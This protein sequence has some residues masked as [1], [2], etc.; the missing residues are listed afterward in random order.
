MKRA[1]SVSLG[2]PSRDKTVLVKLNGVEIMVERIGTGGDV[3]KTRRLFSQLDG[4]VDVFSLG[5]ID[6]YVHL[7]GRDYPIHAAHK[8][9]Q[10]VRQTPIVDGRM[11]KYALEGHLFERTAPLIDEPFHF[12]HAFIPFGTDRI[13]LIQS[14]SQVSDVVWIGDLMFIFGLPIAVKGLEQ[15]K[16]VARLLLP[17]AGYLPISMLF[18]P[19]ALDESPQPKYERYWARADLIA[20]D[21]HYI[22][23]YSPNDLSG[24]TI[25]TNTTTP[26]N[27]N[28]LKQSKV[29]RVIT[30][31]P[32]YDGRSFG[33]NMMEAVLTAYSGHN[34]QL[35]IDELS[36]LIDE[37]DLRP[38]MQVL[39]P[40]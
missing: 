5:G 16:R 32:I 1:V 17:L 28:L 23:K 31:T 15:F 40:K 30:T 38:C 2:S 21:M 6:L 33:V 8:L 10:D 18:P 36:T 39:N 22:R 9:I 35:S 20:G 4:Q 25:I 7:D 13:G 26:D 34:R 11:L 29:Y 37:L 12:K 27:I 19:G 14:V 24:K 3:P